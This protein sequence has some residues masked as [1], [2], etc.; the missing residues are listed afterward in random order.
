MAGRTATLWAARDGMA[1]TLAIL[2]KL[3]GISVNIIDNKGKSHLSWAAGNSWADM[4]EVL[5]KSKRVNKASSD[6]D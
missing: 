6:N 2:L 4:V 5:L 1:D 3:P